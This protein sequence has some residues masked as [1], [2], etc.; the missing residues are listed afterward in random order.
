MSLRKRCCALLLLLLALLCACSSGKSAESY[1]LTVWYASDGDPLAPCLEQLAE[2]YNAAREKGSLPVTLRGF[3][4]EDALARALNNG[5]MPDLLLCSHALAFTLYEHGLLLSPGVTVE[6]Y[7][8]WLTE[9]SGCVGRGFYPLGFDLPLLC[10]PEGTDLT[11]PALLDESS[12]LGRAAGRPYIGVD[13]FAP[14]FYQTLLDAGIEFTADP[15]RDQ[16]DECY[17]NLYNAL[18]AAVFDRGL[19]MDTE[20]DLPCRLER[21]SALRGRDLTGCALHPLSTGALLAEGRGL[22]VTSREPRSQRDLPRFLRWLLTPERLSAA[23]QTSG[24]IPA[25]PVVADGS[26]PL[27]AALTALSGRELHLPDGESQYYA[28]RSAFEAAFRSALELLH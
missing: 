22:A 18:T 26:D 16:F 2:T 28:N 8:A 12:A 4:D 17:V 3:A 1:S 15:D 25:V 14:L 13:A 5:A 21:A 27:A 6:G 7:P 10:T 23:A 9:R 24:L 20:Q 19:T 11:L